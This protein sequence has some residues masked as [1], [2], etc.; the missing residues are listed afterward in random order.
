MKTIEIDVEVAERYGEVSFAFAIAHNTQIV[1]TPPREKKRA[2]SVEAQLRNTLT[3]EE[4]SSHARLGEWLRYAS[5][6]GLADE[7][8]LPAQIQLV[9]RILNGR[10]IPKINNVV[11]AA[12]IIAAEYQFPVGAFDY[13]AIDGRVVLRLAK[14]AE[15]MRP[16]FASDDI[17]LRPAEVIYA[18]DSRVFSRYCKDCDATKITPETTDVFFVVDRAPGV[19]VDDVVAARD[20]LVELIRDVAGEN[21]TFE[22]GYASAS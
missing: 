21:V 15:K 20:A 2:R 19:P 10:D 13:N 7:D 18:D 1:S 14:P 22:C 12:N 6:M 5:A 17:D 11:D 16:M 9:R 8:E 4:M 3:T